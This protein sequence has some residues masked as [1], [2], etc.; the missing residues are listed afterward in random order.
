M[1]QELPQTETGSDTIE[2]RAERPPA[3][4]SSAPS[5]PAWFRF[6]GPSA[7]DLI[8][9]ILLA[10]L[11]CGALAP[12]LLSDAG[13]GWHIRNGQ[14]MLQSH[15]IA[16]TDSFSS[17]M[18]GHPWYAWEWLFDGA[19]AAIHHWTG[20]NGVVFFTAFVIAT[21]F[22][23][24]FRS[25]LQRGGSLPVTALLLA[26]SIGASTIHLFARPH[27]L[28]WLFAAIWFRLLD[29]FE[30]AASGKYRR[31]FWLPILMLLWV[32]L[33]G[34][35]LLGFALLGIYL[36]GGV[37][38]YFTS[39]TPVET[40]LA[41]SPAGNRQIIAKRLRHLATMT[42]LTLLASLVNPYG[43]QLHLHIYQYLSSRF[44]MNHIEEFLSPNFHGVAQQCF[45]ALLLITIIALATAHGKLRP[46]HL[47]VIIFAAYIGLYASRNLPASSIL[48]TLIVAPI[49]SQAINL[50]ADA[51]LPARMRRFWSRLQA[52][53]ERMGDMEFRFRGH[54]WPVA[55]AIFGL[56]VCLQQ[57]R[58]GSRQLMD[59]HFDAK[60]FP[61]QA[62]NVIAQRD[63]RAPIFAPDYWGGYLIYRLYPQTRVVVDDRHDLYGE[64]FLKDY[65]RVT[66]LAPGWDKVLDE[67]HI[68]CVL[69]PDDSSLASMLRE[70]AGWRIT[71]DD[72]VAVLFAR[73]K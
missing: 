26:L 46:T 28:S 51:E 38:E 17:T 30:S 36:A 44:L 9:I 50:G 66:R 63:L 58:L 12:K 3:H 15:S 40:Q 69:V 13:T 49:L 1:D 27:V 65:L 24:V 72:K 19:I 56:A 42:A 29:A 64:H 23:L 18:S 68:D 73:T 70:T 4:V 71:Y 53:S 47:L 22:A 33:H 55:F 5:I 20:L 57:G 39:R 16:R 45:A 67:K 37:I 6:L 14:Q 7:T 10:A 21:T 35:F 54:V 34:G 61:V 59:A 25:T 52:F 8:F 11:T 62:V 60:R 32:N 43:Y 48:L 2:D 31:L 41:A